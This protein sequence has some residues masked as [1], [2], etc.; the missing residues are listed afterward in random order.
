MVFLGIGG[1][2]PNGCLEGDGGTYGTAK[3]AQKLYDVTQRF[4][5]EERGVWWDL[6]QGRLQDGLTEALNVI[7]QACDEFGGVD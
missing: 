5:A 4:I 7:E 1:G 3:P 2:V 6:C